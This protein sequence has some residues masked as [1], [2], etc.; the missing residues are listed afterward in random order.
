MSHVHLHPHDYAES[1]DLAH[2]E[3]KRPEETR[4][5]QAIR[6]APSSGGGARNNYQ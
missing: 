2:P 3:Q 1:D 5:E 6:F 4:Q